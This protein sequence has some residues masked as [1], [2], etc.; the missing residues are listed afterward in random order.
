MNPI[1]LET[2]TSA[3]AVLCWS[4]VRCSPDRLAGPCRHSIPA[5]T[6][7][8]SKIYRMQ[9]DFVYFCKLLQLF[10]AYMEEK[11]HTWEVL[12]NTSYLLRYSTWVSAKTNTRS[13][14][15]LRLCGPALFPVAY[16]SDFEL[17]CLPVHPRCFT[18]TGF[19]QVLLVA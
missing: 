19:L 17:P 10:L 11:P 4:V 2:I 7:S 1:T 5:G 14:A 3:P 6:A 16:S 12:G 18:Y 8:H 13:A 9:T 15:K